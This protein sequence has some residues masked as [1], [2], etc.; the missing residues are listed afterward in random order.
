[1]CQRDP[2]AINI[3]VDREAAEPGRVPVLRYRHGADADAARLAAPDVAWLVVELY[4]SN[5]AVKHARD[6]LLSLNAVKVD[7]GTAARAA[8]LRETELCQACTFR[9][10]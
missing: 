1:V 8:R 10:S 4:R 6:P 9:Y 2:H 7:S 3:A 5:V